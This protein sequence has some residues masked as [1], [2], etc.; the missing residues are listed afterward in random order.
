MGSLGTRTWLSLG[1]V[2]QLP[3]DKMEIAGNMG[4][5]VRAISG[6]LQMKL[7]IQ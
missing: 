6:G 3:S 5:L 7:F 4:K 2:I 1:I